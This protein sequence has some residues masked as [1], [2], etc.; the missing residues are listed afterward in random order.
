MQLWDN[1]KIVIFDQNYK[2]PDANVVT[3]LLSRLG[4][5]DTFKTLSV[6]DLNKVKKKPIELRNM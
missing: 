1:G 2:T 5:P 3:D 4:V 6:S